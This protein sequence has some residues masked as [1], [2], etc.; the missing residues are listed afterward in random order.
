VRIDKGVYLSVLLFVDKDAGIQVYS[1]VDLA[2]FTENHSLFRYRCTNVR[3]FL[4]HISHIIISASSADYL[5][6][7]QN[8]E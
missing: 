4:S 1:M 5:K 8:E 2:L 3:S 7:T 6:K